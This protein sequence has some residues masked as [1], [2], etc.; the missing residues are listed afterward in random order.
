MC[1]NIYK[2]KSLVELRLLYY[3]IILPLGFLHSTVEFFLLVDKCLNPLCWRVNLSNDPIIYPA[4]WNIHTK[5]IHSKTI[6][7]EICCRILTS[8]IVKISISKVVVPSGIDPGT[9]HTPIPWPPMPSH[10]CDPARPAIPYVYRPC[11]DD[12]V[13]LRPI[14]TFPTVVFCEIQWD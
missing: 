7:H 12:V 14:F 13:G 2:S 4:K 10:T 3:D 8:K 5:T 6:I 1:S 9:P 11:I